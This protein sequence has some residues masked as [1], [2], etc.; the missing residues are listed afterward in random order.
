MAE[1]LVH[2]ES[3]LILLVDAFQHTVQQDKGAS[4]ANSGTAVDQEW[5]TTALVVPFLRAADERGD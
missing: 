2:I 4:P 1:E 3:V 5:N